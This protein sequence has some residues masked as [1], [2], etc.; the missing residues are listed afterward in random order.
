MR[1][2][3]QL[4]T[5]TEREIFMKIFDLE[6]HGETHKIQLNVGSYMGGNLAVT[7]VE[8]E[9]GIPEPWSTLTINL[10]PDC[11]RDC[12]YIDINNN[13]C[14]ITAWIINNGLAAPTGN[15]ERRGNCEYPEYRFDRKVLEEIDPEGYASYLSRKKTA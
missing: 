6:Y 10:T 9:D 7:M 4:K 3:K 2:G 5:I 8:W 11:P 14:E 1:L 13:G 12:A 15:V